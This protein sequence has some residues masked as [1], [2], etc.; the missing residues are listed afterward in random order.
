LLTADRALGTSERGSQLILLRPSLLDDAHHRVR[1]GQPIAD[2]VVCG[3]QAPHAYDAVAVLRLK[4]T[5]GVD[6]YA[7]SARRFVPR[8]RQAALLG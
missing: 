5:I 6:D 3:H 4:P 1:F 2:G 7:S 8:K